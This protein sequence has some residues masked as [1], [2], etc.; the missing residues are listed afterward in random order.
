M[1]AK[2]LR[3]IVAG[4]GIGGLT[5]ATAC[6]Q[7]G[8][9][10]QVLERTPELRPVGAGITV[11]INAMRVMARLGL[12]EKV[13]A[14][15]QIMRWARICNWDGAALSKMELAELSEEL[16]A[17]CVAIHRAALHS[18]LL[19]ATGPER[20]R[21]G[22]EVK[23]FSEGE[24]GVSVELA[25]GEKLE[26]DL[27]VG[28]DGLHSAVRAQLHGAA[29]PTYAGYTSWR[30]ICDND[31][32]VPPDL[33]TESWGKARRFGLVP[34]GGGKLYWFA[35]ADAPPNERD[36]D[37]KTELLARFGG[38]HREIPTALKA[39]RAENILRT[40]I[41]DRPVLERWGEG[42][43]T[44]LGDAAHPMTPNAGQGACMAIEDGLVLANSLSEKAD[45]AAAL[46]L[47]EDRRRERTAATVE[48]ARRFGKMGQLS[49]GFARAVRNAIIHVTPKFL[50]EHQ[51]RWLYEFEA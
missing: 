47:Y 9:G 17:P 14:A 18:V 50:A 19:E 40:D 13:A 36:V 48:L 20:V 31:G 34:I 29:E 44:L 43:V 12:A 6:S 38:W 2:G 25:S 37:V 22:A 46:R 27:L 39:T 45:P 23:H 1:E 33:T 24:N 32:I 7:R 49:N 28:A 35:S 51:L 4:G 30:G 41:S 3:I 8:H 42:R 21:L 10:V 26:A 16:G 15:G 11:Q 5:A